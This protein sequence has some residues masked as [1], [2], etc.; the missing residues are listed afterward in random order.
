[1]FTR[2]IARGDYFLPQ[3]DLSS[4]CERR[5]KDVFESLCIDKRAAL[6]SLLNG[7]IQSNPA[8][9]T[10]HYYEQF[11]LSPRKE[12]PY[13]FSKFNLLNKDTSL[14]QTL[15]MVSSV[16]LLTG[17]DCT[18]RLLFSPLTLPVRWGK[19]GPGDENATIGGTKTLVVKTKKSY[20][21]LFI[22]LPA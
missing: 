9:R 6:R 4:L 22:G 11:A 13:N 14:I 2:I 7:N 19:R 3:V 17:F 8:L 1:M 5:T 20:P 12:S 21:R 18:S 10:P 16:S 15:S